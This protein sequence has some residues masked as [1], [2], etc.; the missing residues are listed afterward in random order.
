MREY[1]REQRDL[2]HSMSRIHTR[3]QALLQKL[4]F[5]GTKVDE[6]FT[7]LVFLIW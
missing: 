3:V 4:F 1:N 7:N 5:I 2:T 6:K